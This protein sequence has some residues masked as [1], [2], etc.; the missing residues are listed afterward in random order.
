MKSPI[1]WNK[2][3]Y[4]LQKMKRIKTYESIDNRFSKDFTVCPSI[5]FKGFTLKKCF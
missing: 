3:N 5:G 1:L 2:T 4:N